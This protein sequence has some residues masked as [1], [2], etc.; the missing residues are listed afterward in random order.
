MT[1]IWNFLNNI[2]VYICNFFD[3]DLRVKIS[4]T[5]T[6]LITLYL[7]IQISKRISIN[8][9][10]YDKKEMIYLEIFRLIEIMFSSLIQKSSLLKEDFNNLVNFY[11][12][13]KLYI[14]DDISKIYDQMIRLMHDIIEKGVWED[15]E[16]LIS[17]I[18][19][20]KYNIEKII[21]KD[22]QLNSRK[23]ESVIAK[24]Q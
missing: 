6:P 19:N 16:V 14:S 18:E 23:F 1:Y 17:K 12:I 4:T 24:W 11:V 8:Q 15:F 13:N 5:I 22:L 2:Y 21:R 10:I 3:L 20:Q 9:K 7:W